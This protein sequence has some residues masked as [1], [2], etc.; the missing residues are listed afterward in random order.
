[1][2]G[3]LAKR[4]VEESTTAL[5]AGRFADALTSA[6]RAAKEAPSLPEPH[7]LMGIALTR[8]SRL[9]EATVA[10]RKAV[11]ADPR[12]AKHRYNLA[13]NLR[14]RGMTAEATVAVRETLDIDPD[15]QQAKVLRQELTGEPVEESIAQ[16]AKATVAA[17]REGYEAPQHVLPFMYGMEKQ[18]LIFGYIF[19]GVGAVL[20]VLLLVHFPIAPTGK[21]IEGGKLP[22][23]APRTD[24]LS[25]FIIFLYVVTN[26]S[27][28]MWMLTDIVDLRKKFSWM[29]P[30]L[31]CGVLGYCALPLALYLVIGRRMESAG[32]T[33][34]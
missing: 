33:K 29:V 20:A 19:L 15:H 1:M 21:M 5:Q 14:D 7:Q 4:W 8:L 30:F 25:K 22:D 23:V 16:A 9:E 18:W 34:T 13:I 32:V 24:S 6:E 26:I 11:E 10:F 27:T 31:A 12:S 2:A 17:V 3:E 28:F